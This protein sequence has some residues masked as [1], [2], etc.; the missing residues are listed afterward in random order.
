MSSAV[1]ESFV[2]EHVAG[3][4]REPRDLIRRRRCVHEWHVGDDA[5]VVVDVGVVA[6]PNRH[7]AIDG[8]LVDVAE[9]DLGHVLE[10]LRDHAVVPSTNRARSLRSISNGDMHRTPS[11]TQASGTLILLREVEGT[12]CVTTA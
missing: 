6:E 7:L 2:S 11:P 9:P 1:S 4:E 12:S 3:A 5:V 10:G 8:L